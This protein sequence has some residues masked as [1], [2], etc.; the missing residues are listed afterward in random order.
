[1]VQ[2]Q[3]APG[4]SRTSGAELLA[5][6]TTKISHPPPTVAWPSWTWKFPLGTTEQA[7][8]RGH[9]MLAPKIDARLLQEP[10]VQPG[11]RC[12]K[13]APVR[14]PGSAARWPDAARGVAGN[15]AA[16]GGNGTATTCSAQA[17]TT[18]KVRHADGSQEG[19]AEGPFDAIVSAAQWL[20]FPSTCWHSCAIGGRLVAIVGLRTHDAH[21]PWCAARATSS[22]NTPALDTVAPCS[23]LTFAEPSRFHPEHPH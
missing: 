6:G 16:A 17:F 18:S 5:A 10:L 14:L 11:E 22:T 13:S 8:K 21:L 2:Q 20:K 1:M 15:R 23:L 7:L 9:C 19:V 3:S 4:T 12:W